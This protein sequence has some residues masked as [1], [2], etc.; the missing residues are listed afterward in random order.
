MNIYPELYVDFPTFYCYH[1]GLA[2]TEILSKLEPSGYPEKIVIF[3]NT[4]Q[5]FVSD[6]QLCVEFVNNSSES[7]T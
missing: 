2:T 6:P 5:F 1:H 3:L 7:V 4:R